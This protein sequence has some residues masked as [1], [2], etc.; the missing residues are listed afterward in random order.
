[1]GNNYKSALTHDC[2]FNLYISIIFIQLL[3]SSDEESGPHKLSMSEM[4]MALT[5]VNRDLQSVEQQ[6]VIRVC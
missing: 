6:Y 4:L 2:G 5:N 3:G 1:M